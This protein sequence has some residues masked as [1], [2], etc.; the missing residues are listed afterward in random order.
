MS[1]VLEQACLGTDLASQPSQ[2]ASK[3]L[4]PAETALTQRTVLITLT[5]NGPLTAFNNYGPSLI[6]GFGYEALQ[7]NALAS[8]GPWILV[9]VAVFLSWISD[10]WSVFLLPA[11]PAR[12]DRLSAGRG[13]LRRRS[14]RSV[15]TLPS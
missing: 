1:G 12:A 13:E 9:L 3:L 4:S 11:S 14:Q 7:A 6:R 15:P 5:N 8:V 2:Y 10:R